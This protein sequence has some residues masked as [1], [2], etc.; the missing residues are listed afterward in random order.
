MRSLSSSRH[1][2]HKP[3]PGIYVGLILIHHQEILVAAVGS[4][5]DQLSVPWV[6]FNLAVVKTFLAEI[7][8]NQVFIDIIGI[9]ETFSSDESRF[10]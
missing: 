10:L 5:L 7:T 2:T 1:S 8:V 6:R 9:D 3:Q 4:A